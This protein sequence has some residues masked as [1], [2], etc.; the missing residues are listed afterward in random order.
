[1]GGIG[2]YLEERGI[3]GDHLRYRNVGE[4]DKQRNELTHHLGLSPTRIARI[5]AEF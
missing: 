5:T 4:L 3:K 1:M 2:E